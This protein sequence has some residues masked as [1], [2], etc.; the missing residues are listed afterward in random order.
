MLKLFQ[1]ESWVSKLLTVS[2]GLLFPNQRPGLVRTGGWE[3][4]ERGR[5]R[6]G[7]K[8]KSQGWGNLENLR[9]ILG[10]REWNHCRK[11]MGSKSQRYL[12]REVHTPCPSPPPPPLH[13]Y[14]EWPRLKSLR[15][16]ISIKKSVL[17]VC[18]L[19]ALHR[20]SD[21]L[22][23]INRNLQM[24]QEAYNRAPLIL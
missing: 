12:K 6:E 10:K 21:F 23:R 20:V 9:N 1:P 8:E 15:Q 2:L 3:P 18:N 4:L 24:F 22:P 19:F 5:K 7:G 14:G 17:F 16:N 13:F 11:G